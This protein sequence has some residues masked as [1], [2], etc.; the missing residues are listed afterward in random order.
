M[1][2]QPLILIVD[3]E[4]SFREIFS[5]KLSASGFRVETAESGEARTRAALNLRHIALLEMLEKAVRAYH[6]R[7]GTYPGSLETLVAEGFV[8]EVPLSP[9]GIPYRL[10]HNG[11]VGIEK[12]FEN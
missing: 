4:A 7:T 1:S 12:I 10:Y 6:V 9:F 3:D 11:A 5:T 8:S 2:D